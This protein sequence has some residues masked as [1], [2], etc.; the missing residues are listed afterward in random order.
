MGVGEV[1]GSATPKVPTKFPSPMH[2]QTETPLFGFW[3]ET[4]PMDFFPNPPPGV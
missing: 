3:T 1:D 2:F 4:T